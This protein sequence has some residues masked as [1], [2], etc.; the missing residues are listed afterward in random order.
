VSNSTGYYNTMVGTY[1]GYYNTTGYFNTFMGQGAGFSNTTGYEN[2]FIGKSAGISNT[3]GHYNT[4][5]GKDAGFS[6]TGGV[7]NTFLG[8]YAGHNNTTGER[9][10]FLGRGAGSS[11]TTGTDNALVGNWSGDASVTGSY[12]TMVGQYSGYTSTG[13]LNV[14]LGY[15][16]G[17]SETGSNKL[18]IDNS[19]TAIPL[20]YGD[21]SANY[22]VFDGNVGIN[23]TRTAPTHLLDVGTSGAYCNGGAWVDGSSREYKENIQ[24]LT[25]E[26]ALKAFQGLEPVEYNYKADREEKYLGFIAEDVPEL[27]AMNDRKGLSPMDVVAVLTK[28]LQEQQKTISDLK[29]RLGKLERRRKAE[30]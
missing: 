25:T 20:I 18:Y 28:V 6:N 15:S 26:K 1:A 4:F 29:E 13:G 7:F 23:Y 2:T 10:L 27:L 5:L 17:Y 9:N 8:H 30:K 24:T 14:F 3:T 21:F 12:N 19:S 22:L 16:A 11:N